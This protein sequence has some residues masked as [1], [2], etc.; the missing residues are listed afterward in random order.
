MVIQLVIKHFFFINL[1]FFYIYINFLMDYGLRLAQCWTQPTL[2]R[3]S[4]AWIGRANQRFRLGPISQSFSLK[5]RSDHTSYNL[6]RAGSRAAR[7]D[8]KIMKNENENSNILFQ[9]PLVLLS[10]H[11]SRL[12]RNSTM[13]LCFRPVGFGQQSY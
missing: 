10:L 13:A 8:L 6:N 11:A 7:S 3:P 12:L 1:Y 9:F 5:K 2:S 4:L